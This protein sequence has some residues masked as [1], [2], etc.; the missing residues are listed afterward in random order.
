MK[1]KVLG[2]AVWNG[3]RWYLRRRY[4]DKSRKLF[5]AGVVAAVAAGA[6][7]AQRR[8]SEAK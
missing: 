3:A 5:V 8:A 1:Y 4:A 6:A 2:F 7:F